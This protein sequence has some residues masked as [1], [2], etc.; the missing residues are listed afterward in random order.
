MADL[1]RRPQQTRSHDSSGHD[2]SLRA[3]HLQ[4]ERNRQKKYQQLVMVESRIYPSRPNLLRM[5]KVVSDCSLVEQA[6]TFV[7][8]F[9][10]LVGRLNLSSDMLQVNA[11]HPGYGGDLCAYGLGKRI[12]YSGDSKQLGLDLC[13]FL[14]QHPALKAFA[15]EHSQQALGCNLQGENVQINARRCI[16]HSDYSLSPH[17]DCPKTI[18]A[19]L[20]YLW[21][22]N[23]GTSLYRLNGHAE[24]GP[25]R[26]M[27][28]QERLNNFNGN[29]EYQGENLDVVTMVKPGCFAYFQHIKIIRPAVASFLLIPNT[30][31][32][33]ALPDLPQSYH[34]VASATSALRPAESR[35]LILIDVKLPNPPP[36]SL[37]SLLKA[38]FSPKRPRREPPPAP[39]PAET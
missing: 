19:I 25:S 32:R 10:H 18:C 28:W 33:G 3:E 27:G 6:E 35:N 14:A 30:R 17:A 8:P 36:P 39:R 38:R 37:R 21:N 24:T 34:G 2:S 15:I 23:C 22:G 5:A 26:E 9:Y 29:K 7:T 31:F 20:V 11:P 4:A 12:Q 1:V 13:L 16:D